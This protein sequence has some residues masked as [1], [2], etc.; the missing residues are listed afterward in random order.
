[1][2][3]ITIKWADEVDAAMIGEKAEWGTDGGMWLGQTAHTSKLHSFKHYLLS[4]TSL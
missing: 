4:V 2:D 1:M 3:N